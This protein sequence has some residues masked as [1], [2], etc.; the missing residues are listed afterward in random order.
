M[1]RCAQTPMPELEE[2][3]IETLRS[4]HLSPLGA[5][6]PFV[7]IEA[8]RS[9]HECVCALLEHRI[10]RLPVLDP[11]NQ[12]AL[13]I[14][15]HKRLLNYLNLYVRRAAPRHSH[16]LLCHRRHLRRVAARELAYS[17]CLCFC[18]HRLWLCI[19]R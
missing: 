19:C 5:L 17:A 14:L 9:L 2:Q 13:Y 6:R 12:N 16:T 4:V 18:P 1:W 15:T 3:S 8:N 7:A 10:H 11:V